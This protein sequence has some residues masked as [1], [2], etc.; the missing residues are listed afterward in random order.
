MEN[1]KKNL[2]KIH[3]DI[4]ALKLAYEPKII[5]VSKQQ[6]IESI[7]LAYNCGQRA[8]GENYFQE[9]LTKIN[10]LKDLQIEW[11]FI[12]PIQSNKC[13][14]IAEHFNWV[15]TVDRLKI[16]QRLDQNLM[17]KKLNICIQVNISNEDS[18][19]GIMLDD[20]DSFIESLDQFE[21]LT[22][23]GLMAIPSNTIDQYILKEEFNR[24]KLK[25]DQI[26]R[27]RNHFDTLSMGMSADFRLAL[28]CGSTMIRVGSNIF[29]T[30]NYG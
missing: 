7:K 4:N 17:N 29:G 21:N 13:K 16:A 30:R 18:K 6:G 23:R 2:D 15:Q 3:H 8:F 27:S 12:G 19:S 14:Q 25:F 26:Q 20:I 22:I 1:I 28:E 24:L 5:A 9:G 11:H 10:G